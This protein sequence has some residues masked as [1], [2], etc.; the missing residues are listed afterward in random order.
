MKTEFVEWTADDERGII[1]YSFAGCR[2]GRL[3]IANTSKGVC[4]LGF[5]AGDDAAALEDMKKRFP[6]R[7]FEE[8][9][10]RLQRLAV[11]YCNGNR[12]ATV[13]LHVRGTPFQVGIWKKLAQIPEGS[14]STYRSLAS[15]GKGAR[16]VGN[17]VGAN[18]V[19]YIVPCHRVVRSDGSLGGYYWG[20]SLKASLLGLE[21]ESYKIIN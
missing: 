2:I 18:P 21:I 15:G 11:E 8:R 14:L 3:L 7:S 6:L 10:S 12:K 13:P 16:A 4:F 9:E 17:A 1:E 20:T 19:S 5:S